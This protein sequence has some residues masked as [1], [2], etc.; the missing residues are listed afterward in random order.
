MRAAA[1]LATS[2]TAGGLLAGLG[3]LGYRAGL[4][5]GLAPT[6]YDKDAA[7]ILKGNEKLFSSKDLALIKTLV[8]LGQGHLFAAWPAPGSADSE[9]VALVAQLQALQ[10]SY[11]GGLPAYITN[12]R[13]LLQDSK[14]GRNPFEGYTPSVPVGQRLDFA[15]PEFLELEE[16]G[17]REAGRAAFVL[18]AGGLGE[19]LGYSGIKV[20]L[21]S[22]SAT[23]TCFLELYSRFILALQA[24]SGAAQPLPFAIMTSD[25]THDRTL[26]L[27]EAHQY[28][29]LDKMQVHLVKQEKVACLLDNAATLA[30]DPGNS[31]RVQ[32]KP[33]GHGDVH[34]LLHT[35]GLARQWAQAGLA[36][37]C[38]FQDTNAQVFRALT[39]A[40]G[41]SSRLQLDMNSLCVPRKAKEAIGAIACLKHADG[42]QQTINVEYNQLDPLLRATLDPA[43]D[44]NDSTG[45]SPFPGNIN[46]LVVKLDTYHHV[47]ERTGGIISEF[48]NPKYKDAGKTEF[49]SSTRLECMMQD[50]PKALPDSAKV[51]FTSINQVWASYSPVK[52]NAVD[53]RAKAKQGE[54]THSA[55]SAE[56]DIYKTNSLLL[57]QLAGAVLLPPAPQP[58]T[59][60]AIPSQLYPRVVLSPSF[61][62][63]LADIKAK[64]A[65]GS[66][67]LAPGAVLVL[68]GPGISIK[69]PLKVAGALVIRAVAGAEVEVQQLSVSNAGWVWWPLQEGEPAREEERIRGFKV[70]KKECLELVFDTPGR[71]TVPASSTPTPAPPSSSLAA[72]PTPTPPLPLSLPNPPAS[73]PLP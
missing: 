20:A 23:G 72:G 37:V 8:A 40:L 61:A 55:T 65:P 69:G 43:G 11:P 47:L 53:A 66:I 22:E 10:A 7:E 64:V 51:G 14:E 57:Q 2:V 63:V 62:P 3:Y 17:L 15:S 42:H 30:L 45:F 21:P 35:S 26:E 24:R 68:D 49:K 44:V 33:H 52:N 38:F 48:V 67:S 1:V 13:K 27:L 36:W 34:A 31:Y 73:A 29:G 5:L 41:V 70:L 4:T 59:F 60:N 32:T 58:A 12:A 56:L 50:Y 46:Q 28:Y 9:K 6:L 54:P 25:D 39:A 18:V 19:R 71:F 16:A